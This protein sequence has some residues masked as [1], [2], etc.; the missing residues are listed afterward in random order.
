MDKH[1][2]FRRVKDEYKDSISD[3]I[4]KHKASGE[5]MREELASKE[6]VSRLTY[7][8]IIYLQ[9]ATSFLGSPFEIFKEI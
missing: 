9:D 4:K 1:C 5:L 7:A 3:Y 8:C 6:Y 2:L